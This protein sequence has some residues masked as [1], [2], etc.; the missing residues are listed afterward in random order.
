M[1]RPLA[2]LGA[3]AEINRAPKTPNS[4]LDK[5]KV[6]CGFCGLEMSQDRSRDVCFHH[7]LSEGCRRSG[8]VF[9]LVGWMHFVEVVVGEDFEQFRP[10]ALYVDPRKT[11]LK[12]E[13]LTFRVMDGG[14]AEALHASELMTALMCRL[15]FAARNLAENSILASDYRPIGGSIVPGGNR[16]CGCCGMQSHLRRLSHTPSCL[17]GD[18]LSIIDRMVNVGTEAAAPVLEVRR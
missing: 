1:T 11:D 4:K 3:P 10:G 12:P 15:I 8:A 5:P 9:S 13:S 16:V 17:V 6:V 14:A 18:V 2:S 7:P